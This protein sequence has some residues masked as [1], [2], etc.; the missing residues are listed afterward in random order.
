[1]SYVPNNSI[2][3]VLLLFLFLEMISFLQMINHE[4]KPYKTLG[5]IHD[6]IRNLNYHFIITTITF[7]IKI[8]IHNL[9]I[10]FIIS[11]FFP[12]LHTLIPTSDPGHWSRKLQVQRIILHLHQS[13]YCKYK[14]YNLYII[15]QVLVLDYTAPFVIFFYLQGIFYK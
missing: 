13:F 7:T 11:C 1:M 14:I 3:I 10:L 6:Y 8:I 15:I 2:I 4:I 12:H 9:L 5:K